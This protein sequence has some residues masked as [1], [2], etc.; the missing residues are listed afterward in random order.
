MEEEGGEKS[1]EEILRL[2]T[3]P[4]RYAILKRLLK[5]E[6][7]IT[8]IVQELGITRSAVMHHLGVL[9]ENKLVSCR[10]EISMKRPSVARTLRIYTLTDEGESGVKAT[11]KAVK[12]TKASVG[13]K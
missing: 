2:I 13:G 12:A 1:G 3:H 10:Y 6:K 4:T 8:Q 7:Y 11:T 9:E 5:G